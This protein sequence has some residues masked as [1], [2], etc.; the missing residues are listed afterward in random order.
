MDTEMTLAEFTDIMVEIRDQ[1]AWRVQADKEM[2]YKDGNQLSSDLLKRM[3]DLGIPPAIEPLIG[4]KIEAALGAEAKRRTDW[5]VIPD[6]DKSGQ[7]VA[8][9]FNFKLNQ[10]ERRSRADRACSD[11]Y[12]SQYSVGIGWVE[13]VRERDPFKY[14]YRCNV[15]HRNEIWY[16]WNAKDPMLDD[17]RYLIRKKWIDKDIAKLMFPDHAQLLEHSISGWHS[18]DWAMFEQGASTGLFSAQDVE[19]GW[20]IEEQ[21]WRNIAQKRI[22]LFELW[23]RRFVN[24]IVMRMPDGRVVELDQNNQSHRLAILSGIEPE[25]AIVGRVRRAIWAGPHLLSDEK[26]PFRHSYF[27][28]IPF[29]G[30]K[31]DRTGAPYGRVRAMMYM[32]DNINA[33]LSKI[34]WGLAAKVT[35]RTDGAVLMTDDQFRDEIGRPDADIKLDVD[36]M[37]KP[38]SKFDILE[39]FNLSEQQYKMLVDSKDSLSKLSGISDEF[40]GVNNNSQSGVQFQ[41]AVEQ[42]NQGLANIDDNFGESRSRVGELLLSLI[43]QDSIGKPMQVTIDGGAIRPDR[44]IALNEPVWE[45]NTQYLNNDVERTMLKVTLEDVP[46]TPSFKTQQLSAFSEAFKSTTPNYQRVMMPHMINL[47]DIPN[48]DE[49]IQG[50]KEADQQPT[51]DMIDAQNK[52][53]E[54]EIKQMLMEAQVKLITAQ[55]VKTMT[56]A[57]YAAM[58]GGAQVA[59]IPDVAPIADVIMQ[60]AGYQQLGGTDPNFPQ[61]NIQ[62]PD[63]NVNQNTSPMLPPVAGSPMRGVETQRVNDNYA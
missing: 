13:V 58:Q 59:Q 45:G 49:I 19:R 4:L 57:Q 9:A 24:V 5:R 31:E 60:N 51:P 21:E 14:P 55:S 61:P 23:Y 25:Y 44:T 43:I 6:S 36:H 10:A 47:M 42:S 2:D 41:S 27:P 63:Q 11:A 62:V 39:N 15:V 53:K 48:K 26:S 56:E 3:E 16:D 30:H 50:M 8:D 54:L 34:R 20:T 35:L 29:W 22:Q 32:Q 52:I 33:S 46:S 28:Y 38:G 40:A 18:M 12:E 1:P 17:S 7:E 37:A